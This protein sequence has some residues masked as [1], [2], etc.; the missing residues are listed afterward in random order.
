M[1]V[2]WLERSVLILALTGCGNMGMYAGYDTGDTD[3]LAQT[4]PEDCGDGID[5][6]RDGQLDCG[7]IDCSDTCDADGD[8]VDAEDYGG[9][10][11]DDGDP[12]VYPG[13]D[14][15]CDGVDSDCDGEDCDAFFEDFEAGAI[16]GSWTLMGAQS[17]R[18]DTTSP[19][20]GTYA[21]FSGPI[22]HNQLSVMSVTLDFPDGGSIEF[23]HKGDTEA[24][25]D[26]LLFYI[27]GVQ[28]GAWSGTWQWELFTFTVP[29]GQHTLEWAY[30]KD[31]S[32]SSGMDAVAV[33]DIVASGGALR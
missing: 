8:G 5:N 31:G 16:G 26:E 33:D 27:D 23:W 22:T 30:S 7:D 10:D 15:I 29:S 2:Q 11:C 21:A 13:A 25:F 19:H 20:G 3:V 17:W 9:V 4:G 24:T 6:D 1:T 28:R 12:D 18:V 32:L 14:E